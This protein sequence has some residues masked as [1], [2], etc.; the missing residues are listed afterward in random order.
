MLSA[1]IGDIETI[2]QAQGYTRAKENF[3]LDRQPMTVIHK[4]YTFGQSRFNP[5]YPTYQAADYIDSSVSLL[6]MWQVFG[7]HNAAVTSAEG[8]LDAL[9]AFET[10][11]SAVVK[12]QEHN[13]NEDVTVSGFQMDPWESDDNQDLILMTITLNI[14]AY[15]DL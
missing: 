8:Y 6:I 12:D 4:S 9:D 3:T 7:D 5:K 10:L 15:R 14:D 2:L 11:E 1:V 13:Q